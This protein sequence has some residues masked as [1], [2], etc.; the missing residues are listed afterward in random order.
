[1]EIISLKTPGEYSN[2]PNLSHFLLDSRIFTNIKQDQQ[3]DEKKFILL[4][5]KNIQ[6]FQL[7]FG[8]YFIFLIIFSP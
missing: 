8:T 3:A 7:S 5:N 2:N 6:F 4:P 1:M